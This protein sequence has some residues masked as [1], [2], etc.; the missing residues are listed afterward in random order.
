MFGVVF[1]YLGWKKGVVG[2]G[3]MGGGNVRVN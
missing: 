1:V 3:R 2:E